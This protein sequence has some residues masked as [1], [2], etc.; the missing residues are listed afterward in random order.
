MRYSLLVA[1]LAAL[2]ACGGSEQPSINPHFAGTWTV[3]ASVTAQFVTGAAPFSWP[4]PFVIETKGQTAT[5]APVCPDGLRAADLHGTANGPLAWP[6]RGAELRQ[7]E[8]NP[9]A[10]GNCAAVVLTVTLVTAELLP[11]GTLRALVAGV[12]DGCG[13]DEA[14]VSLFLSGHR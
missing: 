9:I 7:M 2:A 11:D 6:A 3:D 10:L 13:A 14:P 12:A 4:G 1:A 8:C 5:L